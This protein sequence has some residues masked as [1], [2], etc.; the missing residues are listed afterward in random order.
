MNQTRYYIFDRI[1]GQAPA[2]SVAVLATG[3]GDARRYMRASWGGGSLRSEIATGQV[4]ADCGGVTDAAGEILHSRA[5]QE[6][7]EGDRP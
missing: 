6:R 1:P 4:K 7:Q 5:E 3:I 2:Y